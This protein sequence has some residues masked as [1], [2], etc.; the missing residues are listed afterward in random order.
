MFLE[1][2]CETRTRMHMLGLCR[3]RVLR[4]V[5]TSVLH[6]HK[7]SCEMVHLVDFKL[8]LR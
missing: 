7:I 3:G 6:H 1:K 8:D 5:P 4:A 2:A